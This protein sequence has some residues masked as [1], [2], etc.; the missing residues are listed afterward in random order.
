MFALHFPVSV[1]IYKSACLH[2]TGAND[3]QNNR[4]CFIPS[5]QSK[6]SRVLPTMS[7]IMRP[8]QQCW[9]SGSGSSG[10]RIKSEGR[11]RIEV[12]DPD[13]DPDPHHFADEKPKCMEYGPI[14]AFTVF[15]SKDPHQSGKQDPDPDPH[16]SDRQ[17]P[18][19]VLDRFWHMIQACSYSVPSGNQFSNVFLIFKKRF[20]F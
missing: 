7:S 19:R 4:S 10:I 11:I 8:Q 3:F 13:S 14:W 18:N 20:F 5:F 17:D 1:C 15:G 16:Q 6:K 2:T 9:R 12:M